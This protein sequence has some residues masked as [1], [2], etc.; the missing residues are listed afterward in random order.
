MLDGVYFDAKEA[1]AIV[2]IRPK[3]PFRP[4][5]RVA[6]TKEGSNVA[7]IKNEP[8]NVPLEADL[9]FW[10]RRGGVERYL[11]HDLAVLVAA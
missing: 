7:L 8:P 10:W 5:F 9:W 11:K 2:A 4:V 1:K 6:V 3:P